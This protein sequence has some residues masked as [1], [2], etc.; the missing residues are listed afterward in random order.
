[1]NECH[2]ALSALGV[3]GGGAGSGAGSGCGG[4]DAGVGVGIVALVTQEEVECGDG[5]VEGKGDSGA[6]AREGIVQRKYLPDHF[7]AKAPAAGAA[8]GG[9]VTLWGLGGEAGGEVAHAEGASDS[10]LT[11]EMIVVASL[12]DKMPNL[13]GIARTCEVFQTSAL[14]VSDVKK[15]L[16][17]TTFKKIAVS[18]DRWAAFEEVRAAQLPTYLLRKKAE[19]WLIVGLEQASDSVPL[20][21]YTFPPKVVLLLGKEK[22]GIPQKLLHL[23]DVCLEIPQLGMIRSLNVH[24]SAA[25]CIW[26]WTQQRLNK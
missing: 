24:V 8:Q 25:C 18:S 7:A 5:G 16:N 12:I 3:A 19:G 4:G 15:M 23:V 11:G 21:H 1:M 10:C 26:Q 20:H 17:D 22:E 6:A 9:G 2:R 13:A 14:V